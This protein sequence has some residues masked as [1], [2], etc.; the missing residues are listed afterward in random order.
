MTLLLGGQVP[1]RILPGKIN[2]RKIMEHLVTVGLDSLRS[3]LLIAFFGGMIFTFLSAR[4]LVRFG[5]VG[6]IG[7]DFVAVYFCGGFLFIA[8]DVSRVGIIAGVRMRMLKY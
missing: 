8:V 2:R 3:V 6:A 1:L 4:E 7:C 5:A